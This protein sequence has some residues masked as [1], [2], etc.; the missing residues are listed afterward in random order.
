MSCVHHRTR[1]AI[2]LLTVA[3]AVA[4]NGCGAGHP[5]V[6]PVSG[7]VTVAG[8][9][10]PSGDITLFPDSSAAAPGAEGAAQEPGKKEGSPARGAEA[11]GMI[12]A[13]GRFQLTTFEENDGAAKGT[14]KVVVTATEKVGTQV[15]SLVPDRFWMPHTSDKVVTIDGP[16]D[17]LN[18]DLTWAPGERPWVRPY[19]EDKQ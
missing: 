13:D 3:F 12:G 11:H 19:R 1:W 9:P 7:R 15:R 8:K 17:A 4:L 2:C 16:T 14:Y 5:K 6:Y 10:L 18:I